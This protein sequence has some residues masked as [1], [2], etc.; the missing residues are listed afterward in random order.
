MNYYVTYCLRGRGTNQHNTNTKSIFIIIL[1]KTY[2]E[3][4][5]PQVTNAHLYVMKT[6]NMLVG[7][8]E[9][10]RM[11]TTSSISQENKD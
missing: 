10:V 2:V 8:S 4:P 9:T 7:T 11:F 5:N 6:L 1:V 3:I